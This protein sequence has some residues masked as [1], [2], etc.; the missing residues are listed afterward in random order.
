[1]ATDH[2]RQVGSVSTTEGS[3]IGIQGISSSFFGSNRDVSDQGSCQECPTSGR[4]NDS[5]SQGYDRGSSTCRSR[6]LLSPFSCS[7]EE[8]ENAS[9]FRPIFS[10][11]A[12]YCASF[13]DGIQQVNQI[14]DSYRD[15]DYF[16]RFDRRLFSYPNRPKVSQIPQVCVEQEGVCF[17]GNAIRPIYSPADFY[18]GVSDCDVIPSHPFSF[19]PF[20]FGRLPV[21]KSVPFSSGGTYPF[22]YQT[23]SRFG[24]PYFL[25]EIGNNSESGFCFS[26]GTLPDRSRSSSSSRREDSES[27]STGQQSRSFSDSASASVTTSDRVYD[28]SYGSNPSRPVTYSSTSVVSHGVLASNIRDVGSAHSGFTSSLS[29]SSLVVTEGKP[30]DRFI[31]RPTNTGPDSLHRCVPN[32]MGRSS[33]GSNSVRSLVSCSLGRAHKSI[34]DES[35][36]FSPESLQDKDSGSTS[37]GSHRQYDCRGIPSESGRNAFSL[38]V[39]SLQGDSPILLQAKDSVVSQTCTRQSESGG[40]CLISFSGP[41]EHRMGT[42]SSDLSPN[43]FT[44]GP[45]S[46]RSFCHQFEPQTRD[47][48]FSNSRSQ[49]LGSGCDVS[50]LER[51]VQLHLSPFSSSSQNLEQNSQGLLQDHSYCASVAKTVLVPRSSESVLCKPS[52]SSTKERPPL[53]VQGKKNSSGSRET[54]SSRLAT[55][56]ASL[57]QGGFSDNATKR[58][59]GAVRRSTGAVY[60]SKWSIFC[61]WC[62]SRQIDPI[63]V[64]VQQLADFFL[65]LFEDRG[66]TPSTIKGYRSAIS[67]TIYLSGGSDFGSNEFLSLLIKN[68]C[69]ERPRQRRLVP[70]W[71]LGLVL[72]ALQQSPFEPLALASL[73]HLS[74]KCCFLLALA[75]GRR[76]SELHALSIS[77]S[78]LRF[79]ADKSSV[80]LLT[81]PAF[82]AKNQLS[83]KGSGLIVIPA[84]PCNDT[85]NQ[86]LCPV[87]ALDH[88]LSRTLNL[89]LPGSTRLFIPIKKGVQDLSPKSISTWI[90]K[91]V[92]L[93]YKSSSPDVLSRTQVKAHEVRAI[94]SS[95]NVFNAA[96]MTEVLSAG[97]WRSDSTFY[98]HYLRSM[99]QHCDNL[100]SLGPLVSAQQIIFPPT[101]AQGDSAL[102]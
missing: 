9:C 39:S 5:S 4:S 71:D 80:S 45:S 83:D 6:L 33:G 2:V 64:S 10:Q 101:S 94:A 29:S 32:G 44:V 1:M 49:S 58:I 99:P 38:T 46:N 17:Q 53:S 42:A 73:K 98:N 14:G 60:D 31:S 92:M 82:L 79:A 77:E 25:E 91:T 36:I 20:L 67:R 88:Y 96:S 69:L 61:S 74:Y 86:C 15:M 70:P 12:P 37:F 81:D 78:C 52:G 40:G 7:Q 63:K 47:L 51:D 43:N 62:T 26:W 35:C 93:A 102:R 23:T 3:R 59:S 16:S 13:Q 75:T 87:R 97:F 57:R 27:F 84:L 18:K 41:S 21:E 65:Y 34:G 90:C 66:F 76:R 68:F 55:V 54:S 11:S 19:Y 89:R 72:K 24:F 48:C 30:N 100:Y 50:I 28:F 22:S 95:W 56:R 85:G 8:W